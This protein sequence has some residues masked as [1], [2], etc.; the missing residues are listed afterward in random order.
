MER[1]GWILA[2]VLILAGPP[3]CAG[4]VGRSDAPGPSVPADAALAPFSALAGVWRAESGGTVYEE[5]WSAPAGRNMTG[6]MRAIGASG[7]ATLFELMT[8][9]PDPAG[10]R[11]RLRHFNAHLNPW[12][13]EADGPMEMVAAG[14]TD[15][16]AD[17]V[18]PGGSGPVR[19]LRYD[20]SSPGRCRVTLDFGPDREPSVLDFVQAGARAD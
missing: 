16:V 17:F 14:L 12:K 11:L 2:C 7:E 18:H 4:A 6:S 8:L 9:T 20:L 15:G 1:I 19:L 5:T 10:V 13:S 3:A